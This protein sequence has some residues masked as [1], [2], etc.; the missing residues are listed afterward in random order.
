MAFFYLEKILQIRQQFLPLM[1]ENL[2]VDPLLESPIVN[3][4]VRTMQC[5]Q[6]V[7]VKRAFAEL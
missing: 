7:G 2:L 3:V 5:T 1:P 6:R 4:P